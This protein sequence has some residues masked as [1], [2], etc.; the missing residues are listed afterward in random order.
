MALLTAS[1]EQGGD[2]VVLY[3][4]VVVLLIGVVVMMIAQPITSLHRRRS[5]SEFT[6]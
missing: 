1:P 5:K 2:P 3:L 4:Q 6:I